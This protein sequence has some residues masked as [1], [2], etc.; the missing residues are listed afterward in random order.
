MYSSRQ[1]GLDNVDKRRSN[2]STRSS[3]SGTARIFL[4]TVE[5]VC[6][7]AK[8]ENDKKSNPSVHLTQKEH[9]PQSLQNSKTSEKQSDCVKV[10]SRPK[11]SSSTEERTLKKSKPKKPDKSTSTRRK[12][13]EKELPPDKFNSHEK[14]RRRSHDHKSIPLSEVTSTLKRMSLTP[15][16]N[17][18]T[19]K[20]PSPLNSTTPVSK[21]RR[22]KQ[23][24]HRLSD[25]WPP[26]E[27]SW[28]SQKR[29]KGAAWSEE[30]GKSAILPVCA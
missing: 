2:H 25:E 17:K 3:I 5:N 6:D 11:A 26:A 19:S 20:S 4:K 23:R 18:T 22:K 30:A 9:S 14:S 8:L 29:R 15:P 24:T 13:L 7:E 1:Q 16:D 28:P 12:S 10:A 27:H 21:D